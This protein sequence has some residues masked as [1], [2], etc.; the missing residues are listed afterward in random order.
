MEIYV[1]KKRS[2]DGTKTYCC[3]LVNF[4]YT[5]KCITYDVREIAEYVQVSVK[6]LLDHMNLSNDNDILYRAEFELKEVK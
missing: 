1:Q 6:Q 2:K 3:L 5:I 4:G